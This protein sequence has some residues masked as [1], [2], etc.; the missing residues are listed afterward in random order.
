MEYVC[1]YTYICI[2]NRI[3]AKKEQNSAIFSNIHRPRVYHTK[4]SKSNRERQM[5]YDI[6]YMW[7][8]KN[9]TNELIYKI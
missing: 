1:M 6:N 7:S 5:L 8:P 4:W 2:Y 3:L 9:S